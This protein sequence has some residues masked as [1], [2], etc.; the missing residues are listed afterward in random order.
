ML[1]SRTRLLL[2]AATFVS[3][4]L[5]GTVVDRALVAGPAWHALGAEA[6]AQFSRRADRGSGLIAYP[7][8]AI[9]AALLLIAA[10]VSGYLDRNVPGRVLPLLVTAI[11][12]SLVGLL[13]TLKAAPI[14]LSLRAATQPATLRRAFDEFFFWGLY[15]RGAVDVLAF[16]AAVLALS[17]LCDSDRSEAT[18]S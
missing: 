4:I 7:V 9:G 17:A 14:M 6:W 13:P 3:G 18:E 5:A 2:V 15:L 8:E 1:R 10:A 16:V 11:V 12:L